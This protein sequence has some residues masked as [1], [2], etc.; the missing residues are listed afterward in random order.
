M[1]PTTTTKGGKR[2]H[3]YRCDKR[4]QEGRDACTH[5]KHHRADKLEA[6]VW[7]FIFDLLKDPQRLCT[8][9]NQ[10]LEQERKCL[11][12]DPDREEKTW[13]DKVIEVDRLRAGYQE[14]AAK[15]LMTF[16]EL[17]AKLEELEVTRQ[18]ALQELEHLKGQRARLQAL[19]K[20]KAMLLETYVAMVPGRLEGLS[21]EE[22]H[23]G[24]KMLRLACV[25][26]PDEPPE[27]TDSVLVN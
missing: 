24:Y 15:G 17:A 2:Y 25:L 26:T 18:T 11:H 16:E 22:R 20:D 13:L 23:H 21:P 19:E 10:M 3:Y 27:L 12:G 9:L 7:A 14:L 6:Q 1:P 5:D 8:G 4:W